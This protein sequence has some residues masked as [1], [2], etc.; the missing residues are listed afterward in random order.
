MFLEMY[1]QHENDRQREKKKVRRKTDKT[2]T[3]LQLQDQNMAPYSQK[4]M[5]RSRKWHHTAMAMT[6]FSDGDA[7]DKI[8]REKGE[9]QSMQSAETPAGVGRHAAVDKST[10]ANIREEADEDN[11]IV[12]E[13]R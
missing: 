7:A 13:S 4:P 9:T 11:W 1:C 2:K 8:Y 5:K 6:Q 3:E 12:K 10:K